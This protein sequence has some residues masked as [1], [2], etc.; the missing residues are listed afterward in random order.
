M[1]SQYWNETRAAAYRQFRYDFTETSLRGK[2]VIVSGGSGGL[3]AATVGLLAREGADL[4]VGYRA[5]RE[6]GEALRQSIEA[7][8]ESKIIRL[9]KKSYRACHVLG[10]SKAA[11]YI[12]GQ[13]I[14]VDGGL[15]LRRA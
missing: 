5:N 14:V 10:I 4:V 8:F 11:N 2:T 13:T 7:N 1:A 12:T 15:T 6:R 9:E 3:G